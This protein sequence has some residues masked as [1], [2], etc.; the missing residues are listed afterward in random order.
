VET[1]ATVLYSR[2]RGRWKK[3]EQSGNTQRLI[4]VEVDCDRDTLLFLVEPNGPACH[5]LTESCFG[6]RPFSL[7]RLEAIIAERQQGND[8]KSYTR[9]LLA[10]PGLRREKLL[11]EVEELAVAPTRENARWE[12]GDLLYHAMVEMRAK[13]VSLKEVIAELSSR[14][15]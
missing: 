2:R 14:H 8:S 9:K 10:D 15:R 6:G 11:E 5:K 1:G 13:G 7:E 12:A 3:G 4:R